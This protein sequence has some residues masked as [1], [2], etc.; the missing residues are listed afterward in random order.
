LAQ[1]DLIFLLCFLLR[2]SNKDAFFVK[3]FLDEYNFLH[4]LKYIYIYIYM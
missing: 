1:D 4:S 3:M 2:T